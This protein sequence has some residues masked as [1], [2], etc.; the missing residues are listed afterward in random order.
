LLR[1]RRPGLNGKW[2]DRGDLMTTAQYI[3]H[4]RGNRLRKELAREKAARMRAEVER[5]QERKK[6]LALEEELTELLYFITKRE[7]AKRAVE[8]GS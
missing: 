7:E 1:L 4:L 6:R 3:H 8:R 2:F 5:D